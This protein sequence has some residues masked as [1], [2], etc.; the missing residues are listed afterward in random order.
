VGK[1]IGSGDGSNL[2]ILNPRQ[3]GIRARH[4]PE[5]VPSPRRR[6]SSRNA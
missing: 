6:S 1:P 5:S 2:D 4:Q 3:N